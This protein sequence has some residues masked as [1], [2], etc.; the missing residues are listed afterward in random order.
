MKTRIIKE[1]RIKRGYTEEQLAE[2]LDITPRHLQRIEADFSGTTIKML[3]KIIDVLKIKDKDI[4][5]MLKSG[6]NRN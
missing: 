2:I 6:N 1:Y 5:K 4:I 3:I